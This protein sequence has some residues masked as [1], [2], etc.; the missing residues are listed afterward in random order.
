M[1]LGKVGFGLQD[2]KC[3]RV[4]IL[5]SSGAG[6]TTFLKGFLAWLSDRMLFDK[7]LIVS[8][9]AAEQP[10]YNDLTPK[11]YILS[12]LPKL[13]NFKLLT[14][15]VEYEEQSPLSTL[16]IMD[17][18]NTKE[19]ETYN[20]DQYVKTGRHFNIHMIVLIHDLLYIKQTSARNEFSYFWILRS[21]P[22]EKDIAPVKKIVAE[23]YQETFV[24]I[25][26]KHIFKPDTCYAVHVPKA[27]VFKAPGILETVKYD[28]QISILNNAS[29]FLHAGSQVMKQPA[30]VIEEKLK[31][32]KRRKQ[33]C[34]VMDYE[35][36]EN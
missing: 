24:K 27:C 7:V 1:D 6:K 34:Q 21:K 11:R 35:E 26:E 10:I 5:G 13:E 12:E 19:Y 3:L 4:C 15:D 28:K 31:K 32:T 36:M 8:H 25:L 2:S 30:T 18:A 14:K 17:D 33:D 16:I 9:T 20:F 22:L 23:Q 29:R